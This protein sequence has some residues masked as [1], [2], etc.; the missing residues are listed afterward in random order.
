MQSSEIFLKKFIDCRVVRPVLHL[1]GTSWWQ[2]RCSDSA[3]METRPHSFVHL[4]V[5]VRSNHTA[6]F[7]LENIKISKTERR[8]P[9]PYCYSLTMKR[10]HIQFIRIY[11]TPITRACLYTKQGVKSELHLTLSSENNILKFIH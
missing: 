9:K 2:G 6:C 3:T 8:Y 7:I 10:F 5:T 4:P 1:A 11:F